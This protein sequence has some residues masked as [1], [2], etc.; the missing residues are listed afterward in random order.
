MVKTKRSTPIALVTGAGIGIGKAAA[1]ALGK[2]GY[3][4]IVTD[5]L[6][7]EG[8]AVA[9][10]INRSGSAEFHFMDVAD[11]NNVNSVISTIENGYRKP[12]DV[13][14]NNAGIAKTMPLRELRDEDWDWIHEVDLKGMMRVTRAA[15]PKMRRAKKGAIVCLS[16]IAGYTVGWDKHIPYS[17]AKGGIA[18]FVKGLAIE[19]AA[20]K[21]RVNGIAPGLIWTAQALDPKHSLGPKGLRAAASGVPLRRIG[22]PEDIADVISYLASDKAGYITGQVITVDGGL[23]IAL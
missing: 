7:K 20:D 12:L 13:I 23:T 16:S 6:E 11:T 5:I 14:V 22:K 8:K 1:I 2:D 21:I 19:L 17:A 10:R 4:V 3:R 15:S 18:G 9:R